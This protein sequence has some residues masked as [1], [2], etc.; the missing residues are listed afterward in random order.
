MTTQEFII[1]GMTCNH[2]V[3]AVKKELSKLNLATMEVGV[4]FAKVNFDE[5]KVSPSEIEIA[6]SNSGYKVQ[7]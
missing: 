5:T 1:E 2:C 6:I 7:K 3:M 4:G